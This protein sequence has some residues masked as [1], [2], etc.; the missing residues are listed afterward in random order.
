M[1]PVW[2]IGHL[3][4]VAAQVSI[5]LVVF[6]NLRLDIVLGDP[7]K[8]RCDVLICL[9]QLL[10]ILS[11]LSFEVIQLP[12]AVNFD[13]FIL[14]GQIL[15]PVYQIHSLALN[16]SRLIFVMSLNLHDFFVGCLDRLF[17]LFS[18]YLSV[19]LTS[20]TILEL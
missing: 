1:L 9:A 4:P 3:H 16:L 19:V 15:H 11:V 17:S 10:L 7:S 6:I 8:Q 18:S 13:S 12:H 20:K 5:L 2:L 14:L